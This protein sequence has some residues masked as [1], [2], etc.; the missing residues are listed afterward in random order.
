MLSYLSISLRPLF[1]P[2]CTEKSVLSASPEFPLCIKHVF[3]LLEQQAAI[4]SFQRLLLPTTEEVHLRV[5]LWTNKLHEQL[6]VIIKMLQRTAR[7]WLLLCR[8]PTLGC[9]R[10]YYADKVARLGSQPDKQSSE[11]QV[12]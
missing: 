12:C 11:Y 7:P 3:P 8:S 10:S 1:K 5:S 2:T 6:N 9:A 4:E